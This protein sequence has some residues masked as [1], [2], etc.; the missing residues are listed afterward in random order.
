MNFKLLN[1]RKI[2]SG[3]VFD[4]RLDEIQY[5]RTGNK[6]PREVVEH[7][8]GAVVIALTDEG[9][10]P[11][12]KQFRYPLNTFIWELP[13]GKLESSETPE[14]CAKRELEEETG[15]IAEKIVPLGSIFTTPGYSTEELYIFLATDLRKGKIALEEG[16][17]G[18]KVKEFFPSEIKEMILRGKIKD[19]KTIAGM[20][21]FFNSPNKEGKETP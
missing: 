19:G 2:F 4:V 17:E 12:V 9:K 18:M 14:L 1:S 5:K 16:E 11:L 13:A 21:Y 10:I 3:K 6:S 8:G 7:R 20:F 15:Y